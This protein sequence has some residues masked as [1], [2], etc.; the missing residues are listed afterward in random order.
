MLKAAEARGGPATY[1]RKLTEMKHKALEG[2]YYNTFLLIIITLIIIFI[3]QRQLLSS[4]F[5]PSLLNAFADEAI[6]G[7]KSSPNLGIFTIINIIL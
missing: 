6:F 4:S 7:S 3:E 2:N 1:R 5:D